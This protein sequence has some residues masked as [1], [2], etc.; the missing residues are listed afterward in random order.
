MLTRYSRA[1]MTEI[2]SSEQRCRIWWEI[3]LCACQAQV[4][5]G[6]IPPAA[7]EVISR[8]DWKYD[9]KQLET[10]ERETHHELLAFLT[11][12]S[13]QIGPAARFIHQGLT[14]S[15]ILDTA[16]AVQLTRAT[17]ILLADIDQLLLV[18]ERRAR[19]HKDS[20]CVGRSHGIHA[21]PTSFGLKLAGH[22]AAFARNRD[23]LLSARS[24]IATCSLSGAVGCYASLSPEVETR[25]AH[26]LG[27]SPEP[28]S[29]Q[30]I[31]RDRHAY[32]FAVLAVIASSIENLAVEIRHLQ[33]T[34]VREVEE[35]FTPGQKGS[36]AM[37]HKRNPV[38]SE[39]LT[40][41]ARLVR[42][43]V[44]PALENVA[45]WHERDIS[46][47]AVERAIA[48]DATI[49]LD[50]ALVRL[51]TVI[52][53]LLVYPERMRS[54]LEATGGL[55]FSQRVLLALTHSGLSREA[56]Y[57]LVQDH[58]MTIWHQGGDFLHLL[59]S[60]PSIT[61]YLPEGQLS[62]LFD[63][64]YFLRH[65]DTIFARVFPECDQRPSLV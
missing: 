21:E 52:E 37:P 8:H 57:R 63:L 59:R 38:L 5:L 4:D 61:A 15:D 25:V 33:R 32:F 13:E 18:L 55:V 30:V 39:N 54:N 27:L 35:Y 2:W 22:Y 45:L 40:G 31:A 24:A 60:D 34:E 17:D 48:P 58:A 7:A 3:E 9:P 64:D 1:Q 20:I 53:H 23:R 42:S 44:T 41:L 6:I 11:A 36:S 47:S 10:L 49:T 26:R 56:A 62:D 14:S 28:I 46:H 51:T 29:T 16:L 19:E 65:T 12:L 50:F 43:C